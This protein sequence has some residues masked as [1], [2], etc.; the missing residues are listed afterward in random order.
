MVWCHLHS[1][2]KSQSVKE[3]LLN[4]LSPNLFSVKT[5]T[6]NYKVRK[7]SPTSSSTGVAGILCFSDVFPPI[8]GRV[9]WQ[10]PKELVTLGVFQLLAAPE[11][12][13]PCNSAGGRGSPWG[14][15]LHCLHPISL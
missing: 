15:W 5:Q 10:G 9:G 1:I 2:P 7:G 12:W 6:V 13:T 3:A 11:T 14:C 4:Y 8:V